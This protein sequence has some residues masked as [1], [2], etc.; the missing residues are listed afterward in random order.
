MSETPETPQ[1]AQEGVADA[2][3]GLSDNTTVL[4]RHEIAAAQQEML[5]KA[6]KALPGIGLLAAAGFFG[7]LS[8]AAAFRVSVRLL[9]KSFP[10]A[11]AALVAA[12]GY[13]MAAGAAGAAG[14]Q[15]LRASQ[16][17]VPAE[18]AR[19]TVQRV[20]DTAK[21]VADTTSKTATGTAKTVAATTSRAATAA[22][23]RTRRKAPAPGQG[24]TS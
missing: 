9:E 15:L 8:A 5:D 2:V 4:I 16:P 20:A 17:L 13:G 7:V 11:T 21:T 23:A 18:T 24:T 22:K 1:E 19:E 3:R 10:P 6:K 12:T 14:V